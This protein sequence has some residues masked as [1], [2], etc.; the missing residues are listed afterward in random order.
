MQIAKQVKTLDCRSSDI[1][2]DIHG[3]WIL[4]QGYP[5]EEFLNL[6]VLNITNSCLWD[7]LIVKERYVI[8][9]R[10]LTIQA[11]VPQPEVI[12]WTQPFIKVRGSISADLIS[13]QVEN[14]F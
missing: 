6:E 14:R 4:D 11:K 1:R 8:A 13:L 5:A 3:Y 9:G 12:D 2:K 7:R 10:S